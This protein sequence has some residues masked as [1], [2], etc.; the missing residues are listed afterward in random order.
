MDSV[1][2]NYCKT[3]FEKIGCRVIFLDS[4]KREIGVHDVKAFK[5]IYNLCK[6]EKFDIVHTNSTKPG[7]IGRIAAKM[8]NTPKVIH[9]VHG[10]AFHEFLKFPKW[11]FYWLCEMVASPFCDK[12]AFVNRY[13]TK[14][15]KWFK[16]KTEVIYNGIDFSLLPPPE[17]LEYNKRKVKLLFVGR[18]SEPKDPITMLSA[19]KIAH[20]CCHNLTLTIVGDGELGKDCKKYVEDNDLINYVKFEGWQNDV[21]RYYQSHDIFIT[22]SIFE[23]FG[24]VFLDAGFYKLP[25]VATNVEGIPEVIEDKITGFLSPPKDV[26]KMAENILKLASDEDLRG[27]LGENARKRV[28]SKFTSEK[29]VDSYKE[30]YEG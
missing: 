14:Y 20:K 15:F 19:F 21:T 11:Q 29:M 6:R 4:L 3:Q 30:L 9:T 25:T 8:A 12:I 24:L 10:L 2:K 27:L 1:N 13:Y 26:N 18:L 22:T 7:I 5:D 23:A 16:K 28:L 17:R